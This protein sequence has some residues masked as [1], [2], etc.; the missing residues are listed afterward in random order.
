VAS[1]SGVLSS[2]LRPPNIPFI[3][4]LLAYTFTKLWK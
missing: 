2:V 1:F 4:R 3:S